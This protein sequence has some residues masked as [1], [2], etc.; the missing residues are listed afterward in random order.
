ME[1][2]KKEKIRWE[3]KEMVK[4]MAKQASFSVAS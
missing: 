4:Q 1:T 2:I 3:V